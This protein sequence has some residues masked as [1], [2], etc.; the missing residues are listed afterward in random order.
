MTGNEDHADSIE[1]DMH[2]HGSLLPSYQPPAASHCVLVH[3]RLCIVEELSTEAASRVLVAAPCFCVLSPFA[4][5]SEFL[6][7]NTNSC[8]DCIVAAAKRLKVIKYEK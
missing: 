1:L 7:P 2:A 6:G 3:P 5:G 8:S 4:K